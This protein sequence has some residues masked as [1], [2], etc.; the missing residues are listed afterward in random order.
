M[1]FAGDFLKIGINFKRIM[2]HNIVHRTCAGQSLRVLI[3]IHCC[4]QMIMIPIISKIFKP[5]IV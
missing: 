4:Q 2:T 5:L 1:T 3:I